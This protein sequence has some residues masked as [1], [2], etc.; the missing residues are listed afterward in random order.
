L[1]A[2]IDWLDD[3]SGLPVGHGRDAEY[4]LYKCEPANELSDYIGELKID[5]GPSLRQWTQYADRH[6]KRIIGSTRVSIASERRRGS[7]RA[8]LET[9]LADFG[10]IATHRTQKVTTLKDRLGLT[11]YLKNQTDR[12]PV[13]IHPYYDTFRSELDRLVGVAVDPSR[14]FY[15]NS[16]LTEFPVYSDA[17]RTTLSRY[18]IP[19][20]INNQRAL[21]TFIDFLRRH[22][23]IPTPDGPVEITSGY[24]PEKTEREALRLARI[25]QGQFRTGCMEV[26]IG[27]CALTGVAIPEVLRASHIKPWH[28]STN[29]ER[30]DPYNGLLLAA[31]LDALF[32]RHLISFAANGSLIVSKRLSGA[33]LEKL[34]IDVDAAQIN[35]LNARHE[36]Y[37]AIHRASLI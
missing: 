29:F 12:F 11:V 7:S 14:P 34:G 30:L 25:G 24:T 36:Q 18:G 4:H 32:D 13:V 26:W 3:L 27:R 16:N 19:T 33:E 21:G 5:W 9:A 31:H 17:A 22:R 28:K 23:S 35:G 15:I 8:A 37:L 20:E 2:R 1:D 10:L 6:D